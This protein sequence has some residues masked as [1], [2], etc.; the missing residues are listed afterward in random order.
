MDRVRVVSAL[1]F[2][3]DMCSL[4]TLFFGD[5]CGRATL[6]VC[7]RHTSNSQ[8]LLVRGSGLL[9]H[10]LFLERIELM[11]ACS[12]SSYSILYAPSCSEQLSSREDD[13]ELTFCIFF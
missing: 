12:F 10:F 9:K 8:L 13:V 4:S 1:P 2:H 6:E 11:S 5:K 7:F 3:L